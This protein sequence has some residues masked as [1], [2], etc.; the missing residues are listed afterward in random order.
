M[1]YKCLCGNYETN[2][3]GHMKNHLD[4]KNQCIPGRDMASIDINTL[5]IIGKSIKIHEDLSNLT[6]NEKRERKKY[7][8]T[9][10]DTKRGGIGKMSLEKFAKYLFHNIKIRSEKRN[11]ILPSWAV[12][13][14]IKILEDN[15]NYIVSDTKLGDLT[16]PMMLT[17][18]YY[19]SVSFDRINDDLGYTEENIEI[20]PQFLNTRYKLTTKDIKDLVEIREE[21]QNEQELIEIA[22]CLSVFNY[23]NFFYKL[24]LSIKSTTNERKSFNFDNISECALFLIHMYINQGGRCDYSNIPIYPIVKHKYKISPERLD[25]L[26]SYSKDNIVLIVIG[27]N[28]S[29]CGQYLNKNISEEQ[30]QISLDTGKFNQEYWNKCT[31]MSPEITKKIKEVKEYGRKIL[32]ENYMGI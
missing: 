26:K 3:K 32:I 24:A 29:P 20:R 17:N 15:N 27:L 25:P 23:S 12:H 14:V 21:K 4:R 10:N 19:N 31:K 30:R 1:V 9:K 28:G 13:D 18:G 16:F 6:Q 7:Q 2:N 22:N 5:F 8:Q 11:H